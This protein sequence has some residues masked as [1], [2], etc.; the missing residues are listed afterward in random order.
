MSY[1]KRK[2]TQ[3]L[4]KTALIAVITAVLLIFF[5]HPKAPDNFIEAKKIA[6]G[7]FADKPIT[8]YCGCRYDIRTHKI[9]LNSCHMQ[10]AYPIKRAHQMEWE[11]MM[12]A[13]NFG[14]QLT[15]WR[16]KICTAEKGMAFKGRKCCERIS[17]TFN[18]MEAELYNLWPSVGVVNQ[19]RSNFRYTQFSANFRYKYFYG[20]PIIIDAY[21]RKVEPRAEAK[22]I[23]ARANLFM[24]Q[25]YQIK[26]SRTQQMLFES[27]NKQHPPDNWEKSWA[28]QIA[29]IEGYAN[30][31][32]I[33]SPT[34]RGGYSKAKI[35]E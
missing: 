26:L 5:H 27:W 25:R 20:C 35:L 21:S 33:P 16:K 10:A 30:P 23:V 13:E 2:I 7:I 17:E 28:K 31:Y 19:A 11:H 32:I 12:P 29:G 24:A 9:D 18:K 6:N 1:F 15:C 14:R 4:F 8:L 22:G 34:G 3:R